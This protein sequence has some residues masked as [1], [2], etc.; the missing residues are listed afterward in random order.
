MLPN[1]GGV[2]THDVFRLASKRDI[3]LR[4]END[5]ERIEKL[6]SKG[7]SL[8]L[9]GFQNASILRKFWKVQMTSNHVP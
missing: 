7:L 1:L 8:W 3:F 4:V 5:L 6:Y 9:Q 2:P